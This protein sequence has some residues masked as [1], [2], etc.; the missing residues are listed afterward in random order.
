MGGWEVGL[1]A[2]GWNLL[3]QCE[4]EPYCRA[5]LKSRFG[6]PVYNDVHTLLESPPHDLMCLS[7]ALLV[8]LSALPGNNVALPTKG[9]FIR[10]SLTPCAHFDHAT[11]SWSKSQQLLPMGELLGNISPDWSRSGM[12]LSGIAYQLAPL[13]RLSKETECGLFPSPTKSMGKRGWG[14]SKSGRARYSPII[15]ENAFRFGY[16]PPVSLLEWIMGFPINFTMIEYQPSETP[17]VRKSRKSSGRQSTP[18][19]DSQHDAP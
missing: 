7:E 11:C 3:W 9:T 17:C 1:N 8:S 18:S 19:K 2:C 6:V 13:A 16:K 14:L 5:L 12:I 4:Q 10:P 15:R